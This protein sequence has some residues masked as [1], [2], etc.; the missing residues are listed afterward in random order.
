[1]HGFGKYNLIDGRTYTGNYVDGE[2]SGL[3]VFTWPDGRSRRYEGN[4]LNN[5]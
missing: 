1:M 5:K 4:W 3:G 2:I